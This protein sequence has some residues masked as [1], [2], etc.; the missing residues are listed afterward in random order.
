MARLKAEFKGTTLPTYRNTHRPYTHAWRIAWRDINGGIREATGFSH[1]AEQARKSAYSA[2][3]PM[4]GKPGHFSD[5]EA[6]R[7]WQ[8]F[9]D[10]WDANHS[11][12]IVEVTRA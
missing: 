9:C 1:S 12:E 8:T 7:Q 5:D 2:C 6:Y 3:R 11:L 10:H 4:R